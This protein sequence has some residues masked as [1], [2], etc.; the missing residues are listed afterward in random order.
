MNPVKTKDAPVLELTNRDAITLYNQLDALTDVPN[1]I[2]N[3]VISAALKTMRPFWKAY[4]FDAVV[5]K[6]PEYEEYEK[7]L[8]EAYR[9]IATPKG[10]D[11]PKT[12]IV[13]TGK[14]EG[15]VL[16]FDPNSPEAISV[17]F[18]VESKYQAALKIREEQLIA[19]GKW[20]DEP[21][22][23]EF[24]FEFVTIDDMPKG[25][26]NYKPLWDAMRLLTK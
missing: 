18:E 24:T 26:G 23:E 5:R 8:L 17:R 10:A 21:C 11:V 16:D 19:Y 25:D 22:T 4:K 20:L 1:F 13:N 15:T 6:S 2:L 3:K 12:K 7:A 9:K 14:G